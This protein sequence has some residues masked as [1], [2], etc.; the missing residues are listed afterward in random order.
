MNWPPLRLKKL[1]LRALAFRQSDCR[2]ANAQN[3]NFKTLY[4]G[5]F[6]L[7]TQLIILNN[8]ILLNGLSPGNRAPRCIIAGG[9]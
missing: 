1:T 6:T 9:R 2:R 8:P 3:V 4:G 5:Q 7:P